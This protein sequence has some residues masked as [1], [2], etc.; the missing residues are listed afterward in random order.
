MER[1]KSSRA[2]HRKERQCLWSISYESLKLANAQQFRSFA[3]KF[4]G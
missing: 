1:Q 2:A 3:L 4:E